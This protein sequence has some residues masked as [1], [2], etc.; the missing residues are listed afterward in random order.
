MA[1]RLAVGRGQ[2]RHQGVVAL[3]QSL[4][5]VDIEHVEIELRGFPQSLEPLP[6]VVAE[7]APRAPDQAQA[8][9]RT[10]TSRSHS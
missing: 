4:V 8:R 6:H 10:V 9:C 2:Y 5:R 7:V 1:Q 3:E